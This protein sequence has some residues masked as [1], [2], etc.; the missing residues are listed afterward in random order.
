MFELI[1][2]ILSCIFYFYIFL[3]LFC[4]SL[5]LTRQLPSEKKI[6][7]YSPGGH[8]SSGIHGVF[9]GVGAVT[10]SSVGQATP[11]VSVSLSVKWGQP[12]PPWDAEDQEV[13]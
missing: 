2:A 11:L 8:P 4:P 5:F 1:S 10:W 3:F 7:L 6:L 13:K 9:I 12:P